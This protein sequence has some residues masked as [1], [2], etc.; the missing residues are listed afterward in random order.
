M[1]LKDGKAGRAVRRV[2]LVLRDC[3]PRKGVLERD[4]AGVAQDLCPVVRQRAH[5]GD[6]RMLATC[7]MAAAMIAWSRC[8]VWSQS[9]MVSSASGVRASLSALVSPA[10]TSSNS[11]WTLATIATCFVG[12]IVAAVMQTVTIRVGDR[13]GVGWELTGTVLGFFVRAGV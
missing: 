10:H 12:R 4:E 13:R 5:V 3:E 9:P 6:A 7:T 1:V 8:S 2:E 11:G